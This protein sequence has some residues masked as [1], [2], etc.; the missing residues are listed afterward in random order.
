VTRTADL[1]ERLA[2]FV[3]HHLRTGEALP[4]ER[5]CEGRDDLVA[6]LRA[7][8]ARYLRVSAALD[9][10]ADGQVGARDE[11]GDLPSFDGFRTVERIGAGGAGQVYKLVDLRLGRVVAAKVLV[12]GRGLSATFG[13]FLQEAR[14]LALFNDRRIVQIHEFR[15]DADPPVIIMELVEGFELGR[16]AP[17]L[18]FSQ[19]AKILLDVCEALEHAHRLGIQHRDLKPS[20]IMLDLA[21]EPRVLDFGIAGGDP[22]RGHLRGTLPYLA[23][24]QLDPARPI[25]ARTD[26]YA[27]GVIGFEILSGVRPFDG[28]SDDALIA[29]IR[30]GRPR[31]PVEVEP[32]VPEPLQAV[33]LKAMEADPGARYQ[34]AREMGEDLRRFLDGR[35]VRARPTA[36][37]SALVARLTPHLEQI[38]EW[39]R[40][41]L[42]YP[43]EAARLGRAYRQLEAREDDWIVGSRVLSFSQ[44]ALYLGAFFLVAGSLFY[45]AA[46]RVYGV[47][48]GLWRPFVVLGLPMVGL[49]AAA[50]LLYRRDHKAVAVAFYLGGVGLLP[51]FLLIVFHEANFWRVAADTP[52]QIFLDGS[53]SNRQLQLTTLAAGA[54]CAWLAWRTRTVALSSVSTLAALLFTLALLGDT[55]LRG[56]IDEGRWDLLG[57]HL[58]PLVAAYAVAAGA[59]D[60]SGRPWFGQPLYVGAAALLVAVLELVALDGRLFGYLGVTL[61]G[62]QGPDVSDPNLVDTATAMTVNGLVFYAVASAIERLGR[63]SP[64]KGGRG[65][66]AMQVASAMLFAIAPFAVLEPLGY[67]AHT[68]EYSLG[69]DWFYL[70]LAVGIAVL[71]HARQRKAFYYAGLVNSSWA[72][73]LIADHNAWFDQPRWAIALVAVGLGALAAGFALAARERTR[74]AR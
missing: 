39:L 45:F 12:G 4:A 57:L 43:H 63:R 18:E 41:K 34:S 8:V 33:V 49:N 1:E 65:A 24:E 23:P 20:N 19:R 70:A 50:H 2:A 29:A 52:G 31:L 5:L 61:T 10:D 15:P 46:D 51:L 16:V 28:L 27:L 64:G 7:L 69:V 35:P 36:Y 56:W 6:P 71:S 58:A 3:E 59:L 73:W 25:D 53:V 37:A 74:R 44:I 38:Q 9:T 30:A 55:G 68:G 13:D 11:A 21:L 26:V 32:S 62:L 67:L 72:L 66:D 42:I 17:S 48:E 60:Q 54:W 14:A 40:L 22:A 47:I